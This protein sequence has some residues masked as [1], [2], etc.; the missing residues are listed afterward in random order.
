MNTVCFKTNPH[1]EVCNTIHYIRLNMIVNYKHPRSRD[2]EP[3]P[4]QLNHSS[5]PIEKVPVKKDDI[6]N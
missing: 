3:W 2:T 6:N 4:N 1:L 5:L